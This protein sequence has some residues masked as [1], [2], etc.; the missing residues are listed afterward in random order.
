MEI[1]EVKRK[2]PAQE[3][4][5]NINDDL[6]T[7]SHQDEEYERD[8]EYEKFLQDQFQDEVINDIFYDIVD[9]VKTQAIPICEYLTRE[10]VEIIIE[11]LM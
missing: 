2:K 1:E 8:P 6:S 10:D 9:Y 4:L 7:E 11:N 5:E 3:E